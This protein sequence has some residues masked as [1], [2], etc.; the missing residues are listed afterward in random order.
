VARS[1]YGAAVKTSPEG[2]GHQRVALVA[3][4]DP[5]QRAGDEWVSKTDLTT[6]IRCPFAFWKLFQG[7]ITRADLFD[8][9]TQAL[10]DEGI[11]F[12]DQVDAMAEPT[13]VATP[14]AVR[15][16]LDAGTTVLN[17]PLIENPSLMIFGRPDG[18]IP[19][20]GSMLPIEY[21]SHRHL[22]RLDQ[23]ELAFYWLV[24]APLRTNPT[25]VP[26]G[27]VVLREKGQPVPVTVEI[28]DRRFHE[29]EKYLA[30]AR[31]ARRNGVEPH[32]CSC[33][34]CTVVLRD[35]VQRSV[36]ASEHITRISEIGPDRAELLAT[37]GVR[38]LTDMAE[39]QPLTL[40]FQL[41]DAGLRTF[42]VDALN[43]WI[44]H[45]IALREGSPRYFGDE[46]PVPDEYIVFDLEYLTDP[47]DFAW[48]AG[49][50]VVSNSEYRTRQFWADH[51]PGSE[52]GLLLDLTSSL[53]QVDPTLP[54]VTWNGAGA[55]LPAL[56]KAAARHGVENVFDHRAHIDLLRY[57]RSSVRLPVERLGLKTMVSYFGLGTHDEQMD[58]FMAAIIYQA[59]QATKDQRKRQQCREDLLAYNRDDLIAT[60]LLV[61]RLRELCQPANRNGAWITEGSWDD[62]ADVWADEDWEDE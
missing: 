22:S 59:A 15:G 16:L 20:D 55:D 40:W 32:V 39:A 56:R 42:S 10:V 9:Q 29:V 34:V 46:F 18:I 60:S 17:P 58:G 38:N 2:L 14:E 33:Y 23:L 24:L 51:D 7:A 54:L 57:A 35:E 41:Q 37:I 28:P 48:L 26:R 8:P 31:N 3:P 62:D 53:N 27:V 49:Y 21:K 25:A 12:H 44:Q 43:A 36:I 30:L 61:D 11:A 52:R 45:A 19:A 4:S 1:D 13:D 5:N 6:Y 50:T 47:V